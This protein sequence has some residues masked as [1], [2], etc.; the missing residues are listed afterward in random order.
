MLEPVD[1]IMPTWNNPQFLFP[2]VDSILASRWAYPFR[3]I[4]VN[5][6]H[7][8]IESRV[9]S[10]YVKFVQAPENL[11]WEGGLKLGL[12]FS[13]AKFVMFLND[14]VFIP[15]SSHY[16]IRSMM[17][18]FC[19]EKVGAVG[20]SSNCVMGVQN[21]WSGAWVDSLYVPYLIGFCY[22]LKRSAL[23]AAGGIDASLPGGD[24]IDLSIRLR[25]SGYNLVHDRNTFVYHHGFK[26]GERVHGGSDVAGG[27]NSQQMSEATQTAII[28]K[29]GFRKWYETIFGSASHDILGQVDS[30]GHQ[31]R[32]MVRRQDKVLELGCGD[33]KT[34]EWAFG[35]DLFKAG[36]L[37]PTT[38]K[39]SVADACGNVENLGE[40]FQDEKP[41]FDVIIA[42][43]I[44]EHCVDPITTLAHWRSYLKPSGRIILAL[45]NDELVDSI[46][47]NPEHKHA[48]TPSSI[49]GFLV[50]AGFW[51]GISIDP[52]NGVSFIAE[53][54]V[55]DASPGSA[56]QRM[57][58]EEAV[59]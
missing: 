5:N 30:E 27:W 12:S 6:G 23:D 54:K 42:R 55:R 4:I 40:V 8:G 10:P 34:V 28:K 18:K 38:G 7:P 19:H 52:G 33:Q 39:F 13:N 43:H 24:D 15:R 56:V 29:H 41:L 57:L 2:A 26:T 36:E 9:Q 48:F 46:P 35:V 44:L 20:P 45:P 59:L 17:S 3:L 22:M 49:E 1:I 14:D 53:S 58:D 32:Q 16:W 21:I 37:I 31:I 50:S 51:H 47:M 11:G 25:D